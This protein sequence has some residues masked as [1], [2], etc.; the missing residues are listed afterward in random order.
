MFLTYIALPFGGGGFSVLCVLLS[1]LCTLDTLSN[2]L[3]CCLSDAVGLEALSSKL[4]T[5]E[6]LKCKSV[7]LRVSL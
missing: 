5:G 2:R 1:M 6:N 7:I 3:R 4:P